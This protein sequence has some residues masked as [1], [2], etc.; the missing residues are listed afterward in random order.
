MPK[1]IERIKLKGFK[2]IKEMDLELRNINILIGA[3][4]SGKS[5]LIS[6]FNML[7]ATLIDGSLQEYTARAGGA[8]SLLHLGPEKTD[9]ISSEIFFKAGRYKFDLIWNINNLFFPL[10]QG[11]DLNNIEYRDN[12]GTE[13][14]KHNINK[15]AFFHIMDTGPTSDIRLHNNIDNNNSLKPNAA[16]LSSILYLIKNT[17]T[18]LFKYIV[19]KVRLIAP[20]IKNFE[21]RLN[22]INPSITKLEWTHK[23]F[24]N[25]YFDISDL[26]DGTVRFI[27]LTTALFYQNNSIIVLDEPEL[28][29]HPYAIS[30]LSS[31]IKASSIIN[32]S[33]III[34]TQSAELISNFQPEDIIVTETQDGSSAFNRLKKPDLED[35]LQDYSLGE[36]WNKNVFGGRP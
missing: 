11:I 2:S 19:G 8:G 1:P 12:S 3:N 35:W 34:A 32:N 18:E 27:A 16:N 4:G 28:G 29:L 21:L 7:N 20:Y 9:K 6:F 30:L 10:T 15:I 24:D 5:N 13:F 36:L 31:L 23:D 22:P 33:Q 14:F 26:S 17:N 25:A